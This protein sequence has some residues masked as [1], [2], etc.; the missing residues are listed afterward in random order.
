MADLS[1]TSSEEEQEEKSGNSH[2]FVLQCDKV[3]SFYDCDIDYLEKY[4]PGL[5]PRKVGDQKHV[6]PT[7]GGPA[8]TKG[9]DQKHVKPTKGG[10]A[11]RKGGDEKH[12]KPTKGGDSYIGMPAQDIRK[13]ENGGVHWKPSQ[14]INVCRK[15]Q[16]DSRLG[17]IE[18]LCENLTV[19]QLEK[20]I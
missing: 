2:L 1:Y 18:K 10:P 16:L 17:Q 14:N 19:W 5:L 6:K 15:S 7:K 9:G 4:T 20:G 12:V 8:K 11:K 3:V 13:P